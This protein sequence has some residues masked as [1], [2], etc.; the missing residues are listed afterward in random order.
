MELFM[1]Q[2]IFVILTNK[3]VREASLIEAS[4][5][6]ALLLGTPWL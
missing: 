6:Q 3:A 2:T 4:L 5:D 1:E